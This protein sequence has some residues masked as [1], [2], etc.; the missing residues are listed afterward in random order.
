MYAK[1]PYHCVRMA[2]S[3]LQLCVSYPNIEFN[4]VMGFQFK[5]FC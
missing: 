4:W 1:V 3:Y 2:L 5:Y